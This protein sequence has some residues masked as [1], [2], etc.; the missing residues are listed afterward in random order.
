MAATTPTLSLEERMTPTR[1]RGRSVLVLETSFSPMSLHTIG[2]IRR[3]MISW[4]F[5][6]QKIG[7]IFEVLET[8]AQC[9]FP[10]DVDESDHPAGWIHAT[11]TCRE[12]QV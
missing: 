4:E 2:S 10:I 9:H 5:S 6:D 8:N 1:D 12:V 3:L 11:I 7:E